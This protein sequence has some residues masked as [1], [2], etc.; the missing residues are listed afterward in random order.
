[1]EYLTHW[2]MLLA[3]DRL[4]NSDDSIASYFGFA[5]LRVGKRVQHRVQARHAVFAA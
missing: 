5:R 1:M 3:A 4:S 2:R